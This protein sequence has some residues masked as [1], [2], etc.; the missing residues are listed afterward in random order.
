PVKKQLLF[1]ISPLALASL[2]S[3]AAPADAQTKAAAHAKPAASRS[4]AKPGTRY[5]ATRSRNRKAA[6]AR[7]RAAALA[8]ELAEPLP[9]YKTDASGAVVPDLHAEA[10][11]IYDPITNEILWE[12]N[13][14]AQRSIASITKVMTATVFV[15]DDP[16][17]TQPVTIV[18]S[19]VLHASTTYLR[20]NDK[21]TADDLLHLL[22]I[23]SDNAAARAL[24]RI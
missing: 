11:I 21:V 17:L 2:I 12:Q 5:S 22:L 14:Q 16:D 23:A 18:R 13:S 9:H 3:V 6:L 10:A 19:D 7:A 24:A 20:A 15:E 4:S 1:W 8:K